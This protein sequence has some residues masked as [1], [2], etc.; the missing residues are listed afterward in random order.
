MEYI[1]KKYEKK[2]VIKNY[3]NYPE[4]VFFSH[5]LYEEKLHNCNNFISDKFS[6]ENIYSENSIYAHQLYKVI[7][8]EDMDNFIDLKITKMLDNKN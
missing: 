1:C 4:D 7:K 5:L 2:Q 3:L 8:I 6:F